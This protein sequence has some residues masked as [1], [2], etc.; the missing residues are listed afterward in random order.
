VSSVV[1]QRSRR[2]AGPVSRFAKPAAA[3]TAAL[4]AALVAAP[5]ASHAFVSASDA[6]S[7]VA[8][9]STVL[10]STSRGSDE[11]PIAPVLYRTGHAGPTD[12]LRS[13]AVRAAASRWSAVESAA[14]SRPLARWL[15]SHGT[16]TSLP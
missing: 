14:A 4:T 16:T 3:I 9:C 8:Q 5:L 7:L 11:R 10:A 15:L 2:P 12:D 6:P 13:H 1:R